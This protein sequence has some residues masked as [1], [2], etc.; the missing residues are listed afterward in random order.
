[1]TKLMTVLVAYEQNK[2]LDKTFRMK[3]S[4]IDPLYLD[5]LALAGFVNGEE[6]TLRDLLYA[7]ALPSA[8]EASMALALSTAGSEEAFVALMNDRATTLGMTQTHFVNCTGTHHDDHVSSVGDIAVLL[9]YILNDPFLS[10]ML[11]T[12][13][14]TTAPTGAHPEGLV[15][16][17]TVFSY[18]KGDESKTCTVIGGKTGYTIPAGRC[19][20]TAAKRNDSDAVYICVIAGG[21]KRMDPVYDTIKIYKEYTAP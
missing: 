14:Y 12:Y 19:L 8:A 17:S 15:L 18:M 5:G 13:Q 4:I 20:A 6:I 21:E 9:A 2:D 7:S 1:M 16:T 3:Q 11:S 10:E